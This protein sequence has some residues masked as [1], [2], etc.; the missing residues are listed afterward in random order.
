MGKRPCEAARSRASLVQGV[1]LIPLPGSGPAGNLPLNERCIKAAY[2]RGLTRAIDVCDACLLPRICP[3]DALGDTT[4][5]SARQLQIWHEAEAA[6][7]VV[8]SVMA[9][10]L[11]GMHLDRLQ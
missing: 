1:D 4:A 6:G 5:Q 2:A 10:A 7:K 3:H 9:I 11:W 8:A